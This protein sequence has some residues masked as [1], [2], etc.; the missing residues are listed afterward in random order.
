[1]GAIDICVSDY[2]ESRLRETAMKLYGHGKGSLNIASEEAFSS[3][4]A[5]WPR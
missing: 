1:M 5:A 4:S 2:V 3:G